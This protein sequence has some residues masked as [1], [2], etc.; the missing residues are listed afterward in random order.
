MNHKDTKIRTSFMKL[1]HCHHHAIHHYYHKHHH[2]NNHQHNHNHHHHHHHRRPRAKSEAQLPQGGVAGLGTMGKGAGRGRGRGRGRSKSSGG[3]PR[4][5]DEGGGG[6]DSARTLKGKMVNRFVVTELRQKR[7]LMGHLGAPG[8]EEI[9]CDKDRAAAVAMGDQDI[10]TSLKVKRKKER[11]LVQPEDT[12][13]SAHLTEAQRAITLGKVET[14]LSCAQKAVDSGGDPASLVVRGRCH[15]LLGHLQEA[16]EDARAALTQDPS[17]VKAVLVQAEALYGMGEFE[18]S[19]VLFHRG[20]RKRPDLTAFTR[21]IHKAREAVVNAIGGDKFPEPEEVMTGTSLSDSTTGSGHSQTTSVTPAP[22]SSTINGPKTSKAASKRLL[23]GLSRDKEFLASL[24]NHRGLQ[25]ELTTVSV[26]A[27]VTSGSQV[28][29]VAKEALTS[30][31]HLESFM[32]QRDPGGAGSTSATSSAAEKT[33]L[34]EREKKARARLKATLRRRVNGVLQ[35]LQQEGDVAGPMREAEELLVEVRDAGIGGWLLCRLLVGVGVALPRVGRNEDA[36]AVLTDAVHI[37]RANEYGEEEHVA[38]EALGRSLAERG[39]HAE[40]VAVWERRI[41]AAANARQRASL[42]L[43]IAKSYFAMRKVETGRFYGTK[44][45]K[46]ADDG[47]DNRT[48]LS[49]LLAL[50]DADARQDNLEAALKTLEK[51]DA[52]LTEAPPDLL[53]EYSAIKDRLSNCR[54]ETPSLVDGLRREGGVGA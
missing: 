4:N 36:V 25:K 1:Y 18:R 2:Q 15:L 10:K 49:A 12:N 48:A 14:A 20:A 52:H 19:L 44:S 41:P 9:Y 16:L 38:V 39:Q 37:A 40:A 3:R 8:R 35:K 50:V 13:F 43:L 47:H 32:W 45:V 26:G 31:Q 21:G 5:N 22:A 51:C 46:E 24:V 23:G 42:F 53:D 17:L 33:A 34:Q 7:K 28:A 11:R 27:G 6:E 29:A 30:L 54:E